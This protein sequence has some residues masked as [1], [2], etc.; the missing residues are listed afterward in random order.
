MKS[1]AIFE[2]EEYQKL[3]EALGLADYA[4][5]ESDDDTDYFNA[6]NF[7]KTEEDYNFSICSSL[8]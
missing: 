1:T 6:W 8:S 3:M 5:E 4:P 2:K 7:G